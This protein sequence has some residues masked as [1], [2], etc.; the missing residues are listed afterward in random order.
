METDAFHYLR[1]NS[2]EPAPP[3]FRSISQTQY[4]PAAHPG[5]LCESG[6]LITA[7]SPRT[8][9]KRTAGGTMWDLCA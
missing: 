4:E 5:N 3:L 8:C 7:E 9:L 6:L 1:S 2:S